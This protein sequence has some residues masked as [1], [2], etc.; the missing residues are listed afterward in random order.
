MSPQWTE[1]NLPCVAG[2]RIGDAVKAGR[3]A[4]INRGEG[5]PALSVVEDQLLRLIEADHVVCLPVSLPAHSM[6]ARGVVRPVGALVCAADAALVAGLRERLGFV[7]AFMVQAEA[8]LARAS[9]QMAAVVRERAEEAQQ[10]QQIAQDLVHEVNNPLSIIQNYL[11]LLDMKLSGGR[12][13]A[14]ADASIGD[15]L[16][17]LQEE[18]ARV[19]RLV[20]ALGHPPVPSVPGS[21]DANA[22][23]VEVV[24]L[25]RSSAPGIEILA[26]GHDEAQRVRAPR[27]DLKQVLVNLVKNAAEALCGQD[28]TGQP[29][30]PPAGSRIVVANN[31]LVNRDGRLMVE[32]SVRDNGPGMSAERLQRL[33][34]PTSGRGPDTEALSL[35]SKPGADRGRGLAIVQRLVLDMDG[36]LQ[37]RSSVIGTSVDLFLPQVAAPAPS[38]SLDPTAGVT[39]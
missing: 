30:P 15:D 38:A 26:H 19:S 33:F 1:F 16:S 3:A 8:G 18:V 7:S 37:C 28:D 14:V 11:S 13:G 36:L 32:L 6:A 27:D 22:L 39:P 2:T 29:G 24:R 21:V 12:A 5:E 9:R 31:G 20:Q 10:R 25:F 4:F 23:I 35:S 17:V 34:G